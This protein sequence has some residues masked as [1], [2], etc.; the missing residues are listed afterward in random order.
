MRG[1]W[2]YKVTCQ[3]CGFEETVKTKDIYKCRFCGSI[4]IDIYD[5]FDEL[6]DTYQAF[7]EVSDG[8]QE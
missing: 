6:L 4:D 7:E 5:R 2:I 8:L 3:E 1:D